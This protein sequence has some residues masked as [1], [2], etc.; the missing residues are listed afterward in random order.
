MAEMSPSTCCLVAAAVILTGSA[1]AQER[2][3]LD[4]V[5]APAAIVAGEPMARAFSLARAAQSL[6]TSA[7]HWQKTRKCAA[8]HTMAPY[9]MARPYLA[10][11]SPEPAEVRRFFENIVEQRLETEPA[12][13]KDAVTAVV[14]EVAAALA[15]H[16]RATT[17]KLHP[18]TRQELDRMWTLQRPDGGWEWPFRDTPPIK[19]DEHF[20]VTLAA[21]GAG[22]A[23]EN[24]ADSAAA[25]KGLAGIRK[26][27]KAQPPSSLHQK[28]MVM[29]AGMHVADLLTAEE[30]AQTVKALAAAQRPD[31][32][33]SLA[34]LVDNRDD[35]HRQTEAGRK[36]R[37]D[38]GHGTE[39]L[40]FVGGDK[41]YK[42]SLASDAYATGLTVYVLRQAGVPADDARI[43]RGVAWL[44]S[45]QRESGRW[46]TPS[47]AWH[48]H[49][50]IAN[51]GT[52]Y[53]VLALHAC[54]E[55]PGPR[56]KTKPTASPP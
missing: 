54:G 8:C 3:S 31:G 9:L 37:A 18:R 48:T 42:S 41:V 46:F 56:R 33:W 25:R 27:L 30:K 16:D 44:K 28:A 6:D 20:G 7:L 39:F 24:Y 12:L 40:I 14:I 45:Q 2:L 10:A 38:K 47:Q 22:V 11:V 35:P 21:L 4:N 1:C 50:L 43:R 15:F 49:N 51:A 32:G 36:A 34:S 55:I 5:P 52:A 26:F 53:A 29:W 23:P 13:P 17:G 19:S